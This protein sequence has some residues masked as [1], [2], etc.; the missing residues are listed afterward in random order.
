MRLK[1]I[2]TTETGELL[3]SYDSFT[4]NRKYDNVLITGLISAIVVLSNEV[5][6]SFPREIEFEGKILYFYRE[7][8]FIA[9]LLADIESPFNGSILPIIL[10]VFKEVQEKYSFPTHKAMR[11]DREIAH[12]VKDCLAMYL[13]N[14]QK[15][16]VKLLDDTDVADY[17]SIIKVKAVAK[18]FLKDS[19]QFLPIDLICR[20]I[21]DGMEKI[22]YGLVVGIPIVISGNKDIVEQLINSLRMLCPTRILKI[23]YWS[24]KYVSG[25]DI[26]GTNDARLLKPSL[27]QLYINVNDGIVLGG[28]STQYFKDI[29]C[30]ICNLNTIEAFNFIRSEL[31]WI[32]KAFEEL[33]I[34]VFSK[35][36][37]PLEKQL[38]L[39]E[40]L[41]RL[42]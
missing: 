15:K 14:M 16:M 18:D 8:E 23:K 6:S 20:M 2:I 3:F 27:Y 9:A 42:H 22:L 17:N 7:N 21:P 39:F 33:K 25:Y 4:E 30:Q 29:E 40:L 36:S 5:V 38:I 41:K 34:D 28:K 26:I 32:F 12:A 13:A 11:Y 37:L 10:G 35:K 1:I 19:S 24:D 31:N